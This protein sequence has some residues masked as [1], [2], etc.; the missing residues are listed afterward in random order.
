LD[1]L[2]LR[3]PSPAPA[4]FLQDELSRLRW[5]V[6][7]VGQLRIQP[8]SASFMAASELRR[9]RL[10]ADSFLELWTGEQ[11]IRQHVAATLIKP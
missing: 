9:L 3:A 4:S 1:E 6:E 10:L 2:L 8:P 7:D 11:Q 5:L